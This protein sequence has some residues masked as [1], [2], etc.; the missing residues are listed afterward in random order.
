MKVLKKSTLVRMQ[1]AQVEAMNDTC[2]IMTATE[3]KD[4]LNARV[5]TWADGM[6]TICGLNMTGGQKRT[7]EGMLVLTWDATLRLAKGT[8]VSR[9][10]RIKMLERYGQPM[11]EIIY[12]IV[13]IAEGPSGLMLRMLKVEPGV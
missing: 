11:A 5:K 4:A 1:E 8:S 7:P 10:N 12:Q 3:T 9:A 13:S 6:S 2:V